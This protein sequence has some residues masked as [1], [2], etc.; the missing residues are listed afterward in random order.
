M[1]LVRVIIPTYNRAA[2]LREAIHSVLEQSFQ[3]Y[4]IVVAD[5][6]STDDTA[7]VLD[8]A[9]GRESRLRFVILGHG[10]A[11]RARNAAV[12]QP[13]D[14]RY[15]AFLD[16]DDLWLPHHLEE[17]V[18]VLEEE[19]GIGLVFA[20]N[21]IWDLTGD[22]TETAIQSRA[23]R[24]KNAVGLASRSPKPGVHVLDGAVCRR[25][26]CGNEIM[27]VLSTVVVRK[28]A[29]TRSDWF[30]ARLSVM[31]DCA[32]FFFL[33]AGGHPFCFLDSVHTRYRCHGDNLTG[34]ALDLS[35]PVLLSRYQS[36]LLYQ[37][38]KLDLPLTSGERALVRGDAAMAAY[39]LAQAYAEQGD[40]ERARSHYADALGYRASWAA[41]K[42]SVLSRLPAPLFYGLRR[43]RGAV[44]SGT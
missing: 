7:R 26:M 32:F 14:F 12:R 4:E 27:P 5:D 9:A 31:E 15:A 8:E 29:V 22:W 10:G 3:D 1:P 38:I 35:S 43:L 13:G 37:K 40:L 39:L 23:A 36:V 28:A 44:V 6:G 24:H 11:A 25:A 42:S 30:D 21:E 20:D 19:P 17:S 33:A 41:F 34:T 18:R 16:A 2:L